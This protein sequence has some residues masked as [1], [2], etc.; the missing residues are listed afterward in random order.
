VTPGLVA[1]KSMSTVQPSSSSEDDDSPEEK[2]EE[3]SGDELDIYSSNF[4]PKLALSMGR[5][6]LHKLPHPMTKKLKSLEQ[7]S[8]VAAKAAVDDDFEKHMMRALKPKKR[9]EKVVTK[10][11]FLPEQGPV[12]GTYW[13]QQTKNL[14][15]RME[16]FTGP[17]A[18]LKEYR[19]KKIRIMVCKSHL[20]I[21]GTNVEYS[22]LIGED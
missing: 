15:D 6:F 16:N 12:A 10:R 21:R 19:E 3:S 11:N 8:R 18:K 13:T 2:S 20:V 9:K 7:Y 1:N 14:V 22:R 5:R 4:N 17:M